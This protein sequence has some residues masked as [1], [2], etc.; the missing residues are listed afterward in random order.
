MVSKAKT[1]VPI[2]DSERKPT[3]STMKIEGDIPSKTANAPLSFGKEDRELKSQ[4]S[5]SR[6]LSNAIRWSRCS[7]IHSAECVSPVRIARTQR[8]GYRAGFSFQARVPLMSASRT[9]QSAEN[10]DCQVMLVLPSKFS[11]VRLR[12]PRT[13]SESKSRMAKRILSGPSV[14][15]LSYASFQIPELRKL[16]VQYAH[17]KIGAYLELC[18]IA[19]R[20]GLT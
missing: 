10:L 11:P 13:T 12:I 20:N 15:L 17:N 9:D 5:S 3:S 16:R 7:S 18:V 19:A 8:L 4:F 1:F 6:G 2:R 14:L